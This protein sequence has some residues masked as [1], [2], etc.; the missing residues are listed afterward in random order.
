MNSP[1]RRHLDTRPVPAGLLDP[2]FVYDY[3]KVR[4][5]ALRAEI[6]RGAK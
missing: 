1:I 2:R 6:A 3:A 4:A 5:D